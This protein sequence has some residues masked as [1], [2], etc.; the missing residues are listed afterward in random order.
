MLEIK[1]SVDNTDF[2]RKMTGLSPRQFMLA[3]TTTVRQFVQTCARTRIRGDFGDL[4]ARNSIQTDTSDA[5]R[6]VI[7]LGGENGYIAEHIHTGGEIR[8]KRAKFLA[9]PVDRSVKGMYPREYPG[10]LV[11]LRKPD[12]GPNGR[13]YLAKPMK[14]SV[15][16]LWI[17]EKSVYQ[18]PRPW[19]PEKSEVDAVTMSF[20]ENFVKTE[21]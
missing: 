4:I 21:N 5:D 17:L 18:R 14:R 6:H 8:P 12:D 10:E 11:F 1:F 20:F 16:P 13:A 3:W 9:I 2:F 19:W 7:Y 15:K